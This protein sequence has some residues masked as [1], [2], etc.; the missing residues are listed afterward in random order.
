MTAA[1]RR[2]RGKTRHLP[3][4]CCRARFSRRHQVPLRMLAL[5]ASICFSHSASVSRASARPW[6]ELR[7]A[8]RLPISHSSAA[9]TP[10]RLHSQVPLIYLAFRGLMESFLHQHGV[11]RCVDSLVLCLNGGRGHGSFLAVGVIRGHGSFL[12]GGGRWGLKILALLL[13]CCA[14]A[15]VR[16]SRTVSPRA[17]RSAA[18]RN[19]GLD[20]GRWLLAS[21]GAH[22]VVSHFARQA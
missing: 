5:A 4:P 8:E 22:G 6:S 19:Y 1:G 7:R 10:L 15:P 13:G 18:A 11:N 16:V 21:V 12:R 14:S 2:C 17:R 9:A 3:C 20:L